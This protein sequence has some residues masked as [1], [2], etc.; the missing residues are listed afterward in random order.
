M[1]GVAPA[2]GLVISLGSTSASA[3]TPTTVSIPAGSILAN[4]TIATTPVATQIVATISTSIGATA[5]TTTLTIQPASLESVSVLPSPIVGGS[6]ATVTG[7]ISLS[8]VLTSGRV[9]SL[10]SSNPRVIAV[11]ASV[12]LPSGSEAATFAVTHFMVKTPQ[13]VTIIASSGWET[14]ITTVA[15]NPFEVKSLTISP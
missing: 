5:L 12:K 14:V 3:K 4:F 8:G 6:M 7:T 10:T 13:T 15:V 9:V 1:T 11:P 2:G